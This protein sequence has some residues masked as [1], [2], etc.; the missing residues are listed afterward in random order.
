MDRNQLQAIVQQYGTPLYVYDGE[1]IERQFQLL[2]SCLPDEFEIFYSVKANPLLGICQLLKE[3][4]SHIEVAS[5]GELFVALEAG[6]EP[7]NIIYT[8][9]GKTL[10]ELEYAIE[11]NIYSINIESVQE[12]IIIQEIAASR[13]KIVNICLRINPDFNISGA[14]MKMTGVAT[15]FGI[16]Q[17]QLK[18]AMEIIHSLPNV[19]LIGI[20]IYTG[21][22]MLEALNIVRN[23]EEII[24]LAIV[25]SDTYQ[26]NL[27]FLDLGGGFGIPYFDS[28]VYL[29]MGLLKDSLAEVWE[30]YK[31]RL[32]HTR[33]GVESGRFLLAESGVFVSEI[34]YVKESKGTKYLVCDGGSNQHASSAFLG[35]YVRNNFPMYV[36]NK[37]VENNEEVNKEEVNVVGSL[38]TPTDVMGQ[39]VKLGKA[40]PGDYLVI[41]KSGAYGLTHSPVLFLSH[42]L[43]AEVIHYGNESYI[44]RE[45]GRAEDFIVGQNRLAA[46]QKSFV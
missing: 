36:L 21:S 31:E 30:K 26:F 42:L 13:S 29:N 25:L 27:E 11:H 35:R 14:I 41:D 16:D 7:H 19:Q 23:M 46:A 38:C 40:L 12:A 45:R 22:Q 2:T 34:I 43:P 39:K 28:E 33:V 17:S 1:I 4:G 37:E 32:L 18:E 3:I 20:H 6:F 44:L 24:K 15:Q 5:K 9:P 10:S 8:S